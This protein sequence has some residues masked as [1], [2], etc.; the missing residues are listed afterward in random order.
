MKRTFLSTIER[1]GFFKLPLRR[2]RAVL[3][4]TLVM[5]LMS[6][7][8]LAGI[9]SPDG[10]IYGCYK[11]SGG[12]LRVIDYPTVQCDSRAEILISWNQTGP[13]GPQ[14]PQ[15][16][17]GPAGPQGPQGAP[18]PAG[19]QGPQGETGPAG[20]QGP[21]GPGGAIAMAFVNGDGTMI[22][23][24]NGQTGS[25]S[26]NCGFGVGRF[27]ASG[28]YVVDFGF[29][30]SQRFFSVSVENTPLPEAVIVS[31]QRFSN[32]PSRLLI[33]ASGDGDR[34]VMVLVF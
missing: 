23:C 6:V 8:V 14:G 34:P 3:F 17:P 1:F 16:I 18:G 31:F 10:T 25:T 15:G 7:I 21:V 28:Q 22:R 11:R 20:P 30:I 2:R 24:Y 19:P 32:S 33:N 4:L 29:D 27:G 5:L 13:Q 9:P 26:G 12:T